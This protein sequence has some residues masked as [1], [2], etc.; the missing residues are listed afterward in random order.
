MKPSLA[1]KLRLF[2]ERFSSQPGLHIE[3]KVFHPGTSEKELK[4]LW[5]YLPEDMR[6]FYQE[7]NGVSFI[8]HFA[9]H[10]KN[11]KRLP[12]F[13]SD[14]DGRLRLRQMNPSLEFKK[15]DP[16]YNFDKNL[17]FLML[18]VHVNEGISY[19]LFPEGKPKSA[20]IAFGA[21]AEE[22]E[23][24]QRRS[25]K[26]A[27]FTEYIE[28]AM[29]KAFAWYWPSNSQQSV[30]TV[31]RLEADNKLNLPREYE[32]SLSDFSLI[33]HDQH[34]AQS[35]HW[36]GTVAKKYAAALG[37]KTSL[38]VGPLHQEILK[39]TKDIDALDNATVRALL[40]AT[41]NNASSIDKA[42]ETLK[43]YFLSEGPA[44]L[45]SL[46]VSLELVTKRPPEKIYLEAP[47]LTR[48]LSACP[49]AQGFEAFSLT[50]PANTPE[51][52]SAKYEGF[53]FISKTPRLEDG[54]GTFQL[55]IPGGY[56]PAKP[57]RYTAYLD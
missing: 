13:G 49:K 44:S 11:G 47:E 31:A 29:E 28:T 2:I 18:D 3:E 54:K 5:P 30:N 22:S 38:A 40:K 23:Y 27:S 42:R 32:V 50:D 21:A 57:V 51:V 20:F 25:L 10:L 43:T 17:N 16:A 8:W 6:A 35:L 33:S 12:R 15:N 48:I 41:F 53:V 7:M 39:A 37:L 56:L 24:K 19:L 55:T 14:F 36:K 45:L 34:R 1:Q 26:F 9:D 52:L 4:K 46:S